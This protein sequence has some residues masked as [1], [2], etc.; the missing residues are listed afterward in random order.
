MIRGPE[1][2]FTF[3][4]CQWK[5][6]FG[7]GR[8]LRWPTL[9]DWLMTMMDCCMSNHK[10]MPT[11]F[12]FFVFPSCWGRLWLFLSFAPW[13]MADGIFHYFTF[14]IWICATDKWAAWTRETV[15]KVINSP[16]IIAW[17]SCLNMWLLNGLV[18]WTSYTHGSCGPTTLL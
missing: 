14:L 3:S 2:L 7:N 8:R 11:W 18:I 17:F 13:S 4:S 16:S 15:S 6:L 5:A 12:L 1:N 10:M 9:V